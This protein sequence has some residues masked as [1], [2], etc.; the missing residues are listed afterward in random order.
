MLSP[1]GQ[2]LWGP[3]DEDCVR[4]SQFLADLSESDGGK[5]GSGRFYALARSL[6]IGWMS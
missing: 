6:L 2:R 1:I 5:G 3:D 4:R